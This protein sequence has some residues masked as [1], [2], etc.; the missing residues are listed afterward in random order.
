MNVNKNIDMTE[1]EV[2]KAQ[3]KY[4]EKQASWYMGKEVLYF[5]LNAGIGIIAYQEGFTLLQA[6]MLTGVFMYL[7]KFAGSLDALRNAGITVRVS[8]PSVN[9]L[10]HLENLKAF[11]GATNVEVGGK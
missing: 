2:M 3:L 10:H 4:L 11:K 9:Y 1:I 5:I 6:V 7:E 8:G